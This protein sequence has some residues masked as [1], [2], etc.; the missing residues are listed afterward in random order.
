MLRAINLLR[1]VIGG[2]QRPG[3]KGEIH[4]GEVVRG[5]HRVG[6]RQTGAGREQCSGNQERQAVPPR[7]K[8]TRMQAHK[9]GFELIKPNTGGGSPQEWGYVLSTWNVPL[10]HWPVWKGMARLPWTRQLSAL[11]RLTAS[12]LRERRSAGEALG[13]L[14][15]AV[16]CGAFLSS[17]RRTKSGDFSVEDA[18]D[19]DV[20]AQ[21]LNNV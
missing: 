3:A 19:I 18:W 1:A 11:A 6:V 21:T 20:L 8:Q 9:I 12:E 17:L 15:E 16:G 13:D 14:G 10:L 2:P 7:I 5:H 4:V